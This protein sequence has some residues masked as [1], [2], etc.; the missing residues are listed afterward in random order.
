MNNQMGSYKRC[1]QK[2]VESPHLILI[3]RNQVDNNPDQKVTSIQ[4]HQ[5]RA[6]SKNSSTSTQYLSSAHKLKTQITTKFR[7]NSYFQWDKQ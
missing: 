1:I 7:S 6:H 5:I 3:M 4:T 2:E